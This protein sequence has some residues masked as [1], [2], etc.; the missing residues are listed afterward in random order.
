MKKK[1]LITGVAGFIGS[2]ISKRF[3]EEG[4]YVYGI[5]DLSTGKISNIPKKVDFINYDLSKKN[6]SKKIDKKIQYILHLAGQSSGEISFENPMDDLK[7]N[8]I[9]TLNLINCSKNL[10]LKK[11]LYASSMSVYG[12]HRIQPVK[13]NFELIPNSCYGISKIASEKYLNVFK[14]KVPY[15][16]MRMFNVYGPGQNMLNLKQGMISIYLAQALTQKKIMVKG[17]LKRFRDF[18]YIDDVVDIW[19]KACFIKE[20][21]LCLNIG[22]GK[23]T[24]VKSVLDILK[25]ELKINYTVGNSTPGDQFGIYADI[26][27]LK[28]ILKNIQ[29][30]KLSIGL[31]KFIKYEKSKITKTNKKF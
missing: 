10:K 13:E 9:S 14:N 17:S 27:K 3:L 26:S 18:I 16:N 1:I 2:Y 5:D 6:L 22:S 28:K 8:T 21:N 23:K 29:F 30:T 25:Q 4:Y 15:L 24:Y 12:D 31:K 20:K 7:K 11:F 19:F